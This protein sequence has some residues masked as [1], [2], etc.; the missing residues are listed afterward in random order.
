MLSDILMIV[1][2]TGKNPDKDFIKGSS[3]KRAR[4]LRGMVEAEH[5]IPDS[6]TEDG[7]NEQAQAPPVENQE[8]PREH[9]QAKKRRRSIKKTGNETNEIPA[10]GPS[11]QPVAESATGATAPLVQVVR[12]TMQTR[13]RAKR[14]AANTVQA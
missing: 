7:P 12:H 10:T 11:S 6:E 13:D 1:A 9:R 8:M 2:V 5:D 4:N 3:N 14:R